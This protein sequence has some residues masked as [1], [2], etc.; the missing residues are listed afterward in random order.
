MLRAHGQAAKYARALPAKEGRPPFI[1]L[2][3][4]GQS[5]IE[6]HSEFT[7]SGGAYTP[8]PDPRSHRITLE[9]LRDEAIRERLRKIWTEPLTLDPSLVSARVTKVIVSRE[10]PAPWMIEKSRGLWWRDPEPIQFLGDTEYEKEVLAKFA[11]VPM[12]RG[13]AFE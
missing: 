6:V 1:L 8:F 4:V 11:F 12:L 2:C 10:Q 13:K 5:V 9:D 3:D 7:R